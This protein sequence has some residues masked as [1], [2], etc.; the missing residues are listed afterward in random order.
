MARIRV[1]SEC[2]KPLRECICGEETDGDPSA[3]EG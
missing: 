3:G 1:C 2:R